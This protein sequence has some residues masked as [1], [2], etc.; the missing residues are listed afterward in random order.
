[1]SDQIEN[2]LESHLRHLRKTLAMME[3]GVMTTR[4]DGKDATSLSITE[5]REQIEQMEAA[6]SRHRLRQQS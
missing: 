5:T 3:T 4:V 1:M 6:L 2:I